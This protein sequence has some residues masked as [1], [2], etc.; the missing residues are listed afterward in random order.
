MNEF[1]VISGLDSDFFSV[2]FWQA[3]IVRVA[4]VIFIII[5]TFLL[6]RITRLLILKYIS[7][8]SAETRVSATQYQFFKHTL[9]AAIYILGIA[10]AIYAIPSLRTLSV[11]IFAGAGILAAIIGF[12]SQQAFSNI[13]SGIFIV[14]F[15]PYR[16]N[17]RVEISSVNSGIVEDI[18]LRHTVIRSFENK[19]IVIPNAIISN[20]TIINSTLVDERVCKFLEINISYDTDINKAIEIIRREALKHPLFV[21]NRTPEGKNNDEPAVDVKVVALT[22]FSIKVRAYIWSENWQDSFEIGCDL[23]KSI[24]ESFKKEGI[25]MPYYR[26]L[27]LH[28]ELPNLSK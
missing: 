10:F 11:S 8:Y 4:Y 21:D 1:I 25:K 23:N 22:D 28:E 6:S 13:V 18:T 9:S 2:D 14:I 20:E 26:A 24:I 19:R 5:I 7:R 3:K 15:K 27:M 17:D 12:A 16:V